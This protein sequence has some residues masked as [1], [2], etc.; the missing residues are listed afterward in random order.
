MS[1]RPPAEGWKGWD[2]YA[3]F[4]DWENAQTVARRDVPFWA[5]L[6]GAQEGRVLE[7]GCGTG[8]LTVPVAQAG[9]RIIGIDRSQPMLARGRQRLRRAR[10]SKKHCVE[11]GSN[12][13]ASNKLVSTTISSISVGIR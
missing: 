1:R 4:Y 12:Y 8:R 5:R 9:A 2:E 6:A 7:L 3:P 10:L 13:S 11:F